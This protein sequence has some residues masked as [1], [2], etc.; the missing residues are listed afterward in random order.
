MMNR[1]LIIAASI[2]ISI[3][4]TPTTPGSIKKQDT[5]SIPDTSSPPT[6]QIKVDSIHQ[7]EL[8][9]LLIKIKPLN[10]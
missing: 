2:L 4:C 8:D 7:A 9:S 5:I 6:D 1:L 3:S 10:K